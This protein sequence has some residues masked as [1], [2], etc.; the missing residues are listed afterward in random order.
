MGYNLVC[1]NG[2]YWGYNPLTN[3]LL[4]SWDIQVGGQWLLL[5]MSLP[6]PDKLP[7]GSLTVRP[8]KVTFPIGKEKVF[9]PLWFRGY[10]KLP[11]CNSEKTLQKCWDWKTNPVLFPSSLF[12]VTC[13][14][15]RWCNWF[16]GFVM[17]KCKKKKKH[18][19]WSISW[20]VIR[21]LTQ[22]VKEGGCKIVC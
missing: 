8:W 21:D 3:H 10:V 20:L 1:I 13:Y 17:K 14:F 2:V 19:S 6:L 18:N 22:K 12:L 16:G 15:L 7:P 5:M 11:R 9:Q 4:T